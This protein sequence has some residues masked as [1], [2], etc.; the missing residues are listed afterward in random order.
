MGGWRRR[1]Y[2]QWNV[3]NKGATPVKRFA[4]RVAS[5]CHSEGRD[6]GASWSSISSNTTSSTAVAF[7]TKWFPTQVTP[8]L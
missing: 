1:F 8:A 3:S 4:M 5:G 2:F 6:H 7:E